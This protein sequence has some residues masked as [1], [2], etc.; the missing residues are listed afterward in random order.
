MDIKNEF[1]G[2]LN[3]QKTQLSDACPV[4]EDGVLSAEQ[5]WEKMQLFV[6][7]LQDWNQKMN[8]VSKN[9][10]MDVWIRHVLDSAQLFSLLPTNLKQMVDIGSGAGFP[11]MVLAIMLQAKNPEAK[12]VLVESIAKKAAYLREVGERLN[13]TN[14]R[15]INDR[16]ENTVFK[17]VDVVTARAVAA[18]DVLC[19]YAYQIKPARTLFLKGQSYVAEDEEAQKHWAY[20]KKIYPNKYSE[21]G[22]ILELF[23]IRKKK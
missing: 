21:N 20:H 4:S 11:A 23:D 13:L 19:D 22:V 2:L 10:M 6:K 1:L 8:L 7:M 3:T 15:I 12:I 17:G 16:V 18:L 14:V 9:S 5:T